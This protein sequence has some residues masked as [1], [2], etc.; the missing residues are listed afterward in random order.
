MK[1]IGFYTGKVYNVIEISKVKEC[2]VMLNSNNLVFS[3]DELLNN[4][5][6]ELKSRCEGCKGCEEALKGVV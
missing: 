2:C 3:D 5:R 1:L 4:R 6:R